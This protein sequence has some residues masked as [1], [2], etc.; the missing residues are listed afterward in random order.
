MK[1]ALYGLPE[2]KIREIADP[3]TRTSRGLEQPLTE[4]SARTAP[5][6]PPPTPGMTAANL[7]ARRF[8]TNLRL[9][10]S[11]APRLTMGTSP[12]REREPFPAL[13]TPQ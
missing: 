9:R 8:K 3:D 1:Q 11:P 6:G 10:A 4:I 5:S 2:W 13:G 12:P 7:T